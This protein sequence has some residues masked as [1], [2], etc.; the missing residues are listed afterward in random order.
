MAPLLAFLRFGAP[1]LL[2]AAVFWRL[3]PWRGLAGAAA[4]YAAIV[5]F[6]WLFQERLIFLRPRRLRASPADFS[7]P[8]AELRLIPAGAAPGEFVH[9]WLLPPPAP[10]APVVIYCHGIAHNVSHR[11]DVAALYRE[12]GCGVVMF[13]YRGFGQSAG[14]PSEAATVADALAAWEHVVKDLAIPPSRVVIHGHS[15]GSGVAAWLAATVAPAAT[16]TA[17]GTLPRLVLEAAFTDLPAVAQR[18]LPYVPARWLCR[19]Q[20]RSREHLSRTRCPALF[21]HSPD[22]RLGPIAMGER[23]FAEYQGPKEFLH[24]AGSHDRA[25]TAD[26]EHALPVLRRFCWA[27]R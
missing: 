16:G 2:F 9:G 23:L 21:V 15:L 18:V 8:F 5:F 17:A 12:A 27:G 22:D 24:V 4:L 14:R 1:A 26:A 7:W 6:V 10:D 25:L 3:G 19:P 20:Y 11:L 13:D